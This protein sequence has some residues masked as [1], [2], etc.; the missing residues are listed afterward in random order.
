[1]DS[2]TATDEMV[3]AEVE[4]VAAAAKAKRKRNWNT[5]SRLAEAV[6]LMQLPYAEIGASLST[7]APLVYC[8]GGGGCF[9]CLLLSLVVLKIL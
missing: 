3:E 8:W 7:I 6:D 2:A 1:M 5:N 9:C 4:D